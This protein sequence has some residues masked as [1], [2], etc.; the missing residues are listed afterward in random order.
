[1]K[2][3]LIALD[4]DPTAQKVAETGFSLAKE[5]GAE[6]VLLHVIADASYYSQ[7]EYADTTG[8]MGF[9]A[10]ETSHLF[11]EGLQKAM[12][13][14]LDRAKLHLG[15]KTIQTLIKE[16][17]FAESILETA[18]EL[19]ADVIVMGS[20]SRKWLDEILMGSITEKVLRHTTIPLFI[21]PTKKRNSRKCQTQ[22][23]KYFDHEKN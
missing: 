12:I 13:R 15:D 1:L 2:K 19:H 23:N 21:V 10:T 8:F 22:Q 3:V 9:S 4:Y 7:L 17:D 5:M 18:K 16:G 11:E 20:H 14:F 6:V